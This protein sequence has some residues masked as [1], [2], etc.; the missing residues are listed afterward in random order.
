LSAAA[1]TVLSSSGM[2]SPASISLDPGSCIRRE[3]GL[4]RG[5]QMETTLRPVRQTALS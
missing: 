5:L 4:C 3:S 2:Q 1:V